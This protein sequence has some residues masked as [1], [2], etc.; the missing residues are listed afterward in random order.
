MFFGGDYWKDE[1]HEKVN[2]K[3]SLKPNVVAQKFGSDTFIVMDEW[4]PYVNM[5]MWRF[6]VK[7]TESSS[8]TPDPLAN[9][10]ILKNYSSQVNISLYFK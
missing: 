8:P 5:K 6:A 3:N 1:S 10:H 9:H 7:S 4:L 2:N